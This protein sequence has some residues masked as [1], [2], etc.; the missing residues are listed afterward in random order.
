MLVEEA[1]S[2]DELDVGEL[3]DK[4]QR[5]ESELESAEEGSEEYRVA[6]RDKRRWQAFI[7]VAENASP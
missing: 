5:A 2:P 3:R 7:A 6:E 4:L 1:H